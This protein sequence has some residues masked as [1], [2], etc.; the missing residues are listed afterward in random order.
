M[1]RARCDVVLGG[2]VRANG[3]N[4]ARMA[5]LHPIVP[6]LP[7]QTRDRTA[8]APPIVIDGAAAVSGCSAPVRAATQPSSADFS[9][10]RPTPPRSSARL[11]NALFENAAPSRAFTSSR[12]CS[13]MRWPTLYEGA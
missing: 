4:D 10:S 12:I 2:V 11:W 9:V 5:T 7:R 13:Q 6:P 1:D 3:Q 8:A